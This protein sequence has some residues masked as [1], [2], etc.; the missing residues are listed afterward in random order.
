MDAS[1]DT[2][3]MGD[4]IFSTFPPNLFSFQVAS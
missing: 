1:I 2:P 4:N 3:D